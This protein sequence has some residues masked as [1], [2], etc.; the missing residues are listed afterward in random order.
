MMLENPKRSSAS[1]SKTTSLSPN[2]L[3]HDVPLDG[4]RSILPE[5]IPCAV[6]AILQSFPPTCTQSKAKSRSLRASKA[7]TGKG[8]PDDLAEY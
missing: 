4:Q 3:Q 6:L 5:E 7:S 1:F 8:L 2:P